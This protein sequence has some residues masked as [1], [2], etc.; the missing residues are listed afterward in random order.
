MA[1]R[2]RE[3]PVLSAVRLLA[4]ML[5][6][7]ADRPRLFWSS[8]QTLESRFGGSPRFGEVLETVQ[9]Q[10]RR[11]VHR[12]VLRAVCDVSF[13]RDERTWRLRA[14]QVADEPAVLVGLF[15][16]ELA[17]VEVQ[18]RQSSDLFPVHLLQCVPVELFGLVEEPSDFLFLSVAVGGVFGVF[19]GRSGLEEGVRGRFVTRGYAC[20][21][22]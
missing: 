10:A 5:T 8:P 1:R 15:V 6:D 2:W 13:R 12:Q 4:D 18:L 21:A 22:E 3:V 11:R 14:P 19:R 16:E 20:A 7:Q 9:A 17:R